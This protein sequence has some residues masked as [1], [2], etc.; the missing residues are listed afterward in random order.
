M[1]VSVHTVTEPWD[2]QNNQHSWRQFKETIHPSFC[3]R[4]TDSYWLL[5][6]KQLVP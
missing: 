5:M 3:W 1:A 2:D 4:V 6:L